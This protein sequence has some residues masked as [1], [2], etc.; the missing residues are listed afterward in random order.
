[1][2]PITPIT[3]LQAFNVP[4]AEEAVVDKPTNSK[5]NPKP[6]EKIHLCVD[7]ELIL[8]PGYGTDKKKLVKA[9]CSSDTTKSTEPPTKVVLGDAQ[10]WI[11]QGRRIINYEK[12]SPA[13]ALNRL[14]LQYL[15]E[16]DASTYHINE[17]DIVRSA[18]VHLLH[19][20]NQA[21]WQH[22]C[23]D[24]EKATVRCQAESIAEHIR[25][26]IAYFRNDSHGMRPFAVIEMKRR[27]IIKKHEFE[28]AAKPQGRKDKAPEEGDIAT[29]GFKNCSL[30]LMK[31][32][33][34]YAIG[35]GTQYVV[36]FDWDYLILCFF[37]DLDV[38]KPLDWR[39]EKGIGSKCVV[40]I[41]PFNP[42][43]HKMR[44]CLLGFLAE[45]FVETPE[46][47]KD[48]N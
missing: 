30:I 44:I 28:N 29:A 42:E 26:D 40:T 2:A 11:K 31:Q 8:L 22:T 9:S 14:T 45:A 21:L 27:G 18:A 32:A 48:Q 34:S 25:N 43:S 41:I 3:I 6:S 16:E 4:A 10:H 15:A 12:S 13:P 37:P 35:R 7:P 23:S 5:N 33:S 20:V 19:P 39:R 38:N 1:M 36:L 24:D 47:V 46:K 17:A